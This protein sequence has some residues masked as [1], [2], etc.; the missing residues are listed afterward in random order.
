M[1]RHIACWTPS[2]LLLAAGFAS[3]QETTEQADALALIAKINGKAT[4]DPENPKRVIGID[5]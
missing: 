1:L 4:F 2:L 3:P 5:I